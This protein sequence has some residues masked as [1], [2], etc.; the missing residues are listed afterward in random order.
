MLRF[1]SKGTYDLVMLDLNMRDIKGDR[2]SLMLRMEK[3]HEKA[4]CA[5]VSVA[6]I[7][8]HVLVAV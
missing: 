4:R 3:E 5:C 1:L 7:C 6:A 2:L 8:A